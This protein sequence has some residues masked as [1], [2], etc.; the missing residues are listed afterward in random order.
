MSERPLGRGGSRVALFGPLR[1]DRIIARPV[2][3][4]LHQE[5]DWVAA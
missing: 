4:G 5:Y 3:G 1:A 2:L